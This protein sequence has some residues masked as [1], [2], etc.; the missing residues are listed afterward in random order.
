L[1]G[2][3]AVANPA[4]GVTQGAPKPLGFDALRAVLESHGWIV[5][6]DGDGSLRLFFGASQKKPAEA[7]ETTKPSA[8]KWLDELQAKLQAAGWR[9]TRDDTGSLILPLSDTQPT[10]AWTAPL[11]EAEEESAP[12]RRPLGYDA[13]RAVLEAHGWRVERDSD[14]SLRLFFGVSQEP[15]AE[16]RDQKATA[17]ATWLDELQTRLQATGWRVMRDETGSLILPLGKSPDA[18]GDGVPNDQDMCTDTAQGVNVNEFGC[19]QA[20]PVVLEGVNFKFGSAELTENSQSILDKQIEILRKIPNL[21]IKVVGHTDS[22]GTAEI[23]QTISELRAASVRNYL[24]ENGLGFAKVTSEGRGDE[25]PLANNRTRAGR[26]KNRRVELL[27][28]G[29]ARQ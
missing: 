23:N 6:R 12:S 10:P 20:G 16:A 15:P 5:E 17:A 26:A 21:A 1:G 13:L 25:E 27:S 18:D 28:L 24:I 19:A 4:G 7:R 22:A 3:A 29:S 2:I 9:V 14:G 11:Q 8:A